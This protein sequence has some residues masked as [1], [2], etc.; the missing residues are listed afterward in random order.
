MG[1]K[2]PALQNLYLYLQGVADSVDA[3]SVSMLGAGCRKLESCIELGNGAG[4]EELRSMGCI[5]VG[6]THTS[7]TARTAQAPQAVQTAHTAKMEVSTGS[8]SRSR[9]YKPFAGVT[10]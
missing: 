9:Q 6:G 2:P 1:V 8:W 3:A 10:R 4:L 7:L 5:L